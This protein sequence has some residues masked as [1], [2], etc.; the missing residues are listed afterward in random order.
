MSESPQ[1]K[2]TNCGI[3]FPPE[4]ALQIKFCFNCGHKQVR[5]DQDTC[6][7]SSSNIDTSIDINDN[8]SS[9]EREKV[10]YTFVNQDKQP[11]RLSDSPTV[12]PRSTGHD[13]SGA[14]TVNQ[15]DFS[16]E[17]L[18]NGKQSESEKNDA[19]ESDKISLV[20]NQNGLEETTV[21]V[22]QTH[23]TEIDNAPTPVDEHHED[24]HDSCSVSDKDRCTS[25][26]RTGAHSG[27]DNVMDSE[28]DRFLT[29]SPVTLTDEV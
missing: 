20:T 1:N 27:N 15:P 13:S 17:T 12:V 16:E 14:D 21:S 28:S 11:A 8:G 7:P 18:T 26:E 25:E 5:G 9:S 4:S 22:L 29:P 24:D 3:L 10:P 6:K 2:C 19:T 23:S